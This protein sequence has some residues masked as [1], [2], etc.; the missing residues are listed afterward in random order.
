[1]GTGKLLGNDLQWTSIL[2]RG[3]RNTPSRFML[4][5]PGI[6]SNRKASFFCVCVFGIASSKN[7]SIWLTYEN[8][9]V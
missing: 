5:T 4:Q 9:W 2:S 7:V 1:M 6:S 8:L 3:S